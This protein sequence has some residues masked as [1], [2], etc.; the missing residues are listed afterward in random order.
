MNYEPRIFQADASVFPDPLEDKTALRGIPQSRREYILRYM[1]PRDR[2]LSLCAWRLLERVFEQYGFGMEN[3]RIGEHGKPL[4]PGIYFNLSHSGDMAVC[5][6]GNGEIGVDVEKCENAP[7]DIF[8][9]AFT[10]KEREFIE[11]AA[12]TQEKTRRF[13]RL[14]TIKESFMKMTGLGLS[15][16]PGDIEINVSERKVL[17]QGVTQDCV[18]FARSCGA[19][20]IAAVVGREREVR[21]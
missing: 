19:Y 21:K 5:G 6:V 4:C 8:G 9:E 10:E 2:K 3:I 12:D 11:S 7:F 1:F 15:I 14:W 18:Y 20:E 16:S 17:F 13:F